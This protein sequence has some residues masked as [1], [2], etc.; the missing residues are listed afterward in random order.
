MA[1]TVTSSS[2]GTTTSSGTINAPTGTANGDLLFFSWCADN[3]S[4]TIALAGTTLTALGWTQVGS[5][6]HTSTVDGQSFET[7]SKIASSEPS[8]WSVVPGGSGDASCIMVRVAGMATSSP[9]EVSFVTQDTSGQSG[10]TLNAPNSGVTTS[11]DGDLLLYFGTVDFNAAGTISFT[12]PSGYTSATTV[13]SGAWTG[14]QAAY[15]VQTSHG[16]TGTVQGQL[17]NASA[18]AGI[19]QSA[20]IA[21]KTGATSIIQKSAKVFGV[22]ATSFSP[23]LSSVTAHNSLLMIVAFSQNIANSTVPTDSSGQVWSYAG[24]YLPSS[25]GPAG[26]FIYYLLDANAG[27]H[28]LTW[29]QPSGTWATLQLVETVPLSALD[30]V[31][32][33]VTATTTSPLVGNS[34]TTTGTSDLVI[35]VLSIDN[36]N[37]NSAL[38]ISDPPTGTT[39]YTSGD[40]FNDSTSYMGFEWCY[41]DVAA[42]ATGTATWTYSTADSGQ[43]IAGGLVAFTKV[44][45]GAV[46]PTINTQPTLALVNTGGTATFTVSAT[47]SGGTLTYQWQDNST[48]S[49][50]NISGATS[51]SYTTGTVGYS[52]QGRLYQVVVTDSNGSTTSS[53]AALSVQFNLIGTG[54]RSI[55]VSGYQFGS[56]SFESFIRSTITASGR[57]KVKVWSGSAWVPGKAVKTW[58]GSAWVVKP[59]KYWNTSTSSWITCDPPSL[60]FRSATTSG[61]TSFAASTISAAAPTGAAV[62]DLEIIFFTTGVTSGATNH[63]TPG[64]TGGAWNVGGTFTKT[65]LAGGALNGRG[66]LYWRIAT[67]TPAAVTLTADTNAA[68][69]FFRYAYQNPLAAGAFG[70]VSFAYFASGTSIVETGITTT[71][72]NSLI[73]QGITQTAAQ[74]AAPDAQLTERSDSATYGI[75]GADKQQITAGATGNFTCV[76]PTAADGYYFIAE[77]WSAGSA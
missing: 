14:L 5:S 33:G 38:G 18:S 13:T 35:G 74:L 20:L 60:A 65:G 59:V 52:W 39:T 46:G 61:D 75:E 43:T 44:P 12:A 76:L 2:L 28:T 66:T 51:S 8:S 23:T 69:T 49:F 19:G 15:T 58:S 17:T 30:V 22:G 32:T 26:Y 53:T 16:A 68:M 42:G 21:I 50:A 77:F 64:S 10:T 34:V 54:P 1:Y 25:G 48:G 9:I 57:G 73:L 63:T 4:A 37:G 71:K 29:S 67:A 70:Q 72:T 27:T 36:S 45:P 3:P 7:W 41:A 11:T 56:G 47:T 6:Q 62:G 55:P 31:G 40:V 24:G